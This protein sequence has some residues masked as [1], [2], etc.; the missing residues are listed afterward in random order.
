MKVG[1]AYSYHHR[2]RPK[3]EGP[4]ATR[5]CCLPH[6]LER[7]ETDFQRNL[8]RIICSLLRSQRSALLFSARGP[9]D[10]PHGGSYAVCIRT[11]AA[12]WVETLALASIIIFFFIPP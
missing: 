12:F 3:P 2:R 1:D 11:A 8:G 7:V 4:W 9:E 10:G 6:F 5:P